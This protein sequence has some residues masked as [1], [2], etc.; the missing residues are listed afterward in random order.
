MTK[1]SLSNLGRN[2]TEMKNAINRDQSIESTDYAAFDSANKHTLKKNI[3]S[4]KKSSN[5]NFEK[6]RRSEM[7]QHNIRVSNVSSI[8]AH[9]V[10]PT[11]GEE[12]ASK[13]RTKEEFI[14]P[15]QE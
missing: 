5:S 1:A 2:R 15:T 9:L 7:L 3:K 14:E 11:L 8:V 10:E 13:E 12:N 6:E 4:S